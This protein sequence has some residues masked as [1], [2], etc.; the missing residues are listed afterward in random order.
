MAGRLLQELIPRDPQTLGAA[1][2]LDKHPLLWNDAGPWQSTWL[3][4][5]H[6]AEFWA[7]GLVGFGA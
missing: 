7:P 5:T 3:G 4:E 1:E 6:M 2:K